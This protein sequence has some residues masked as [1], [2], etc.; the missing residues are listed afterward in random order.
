MAVT[1]Q[2]KAEMLVKKIVNIH[3][4]S[5]ISE[6]G[7]RGREATIE[8]NRELLEQKEDNNNL[9]NVTFVKA[10][11][12]CVLM[13]TK[14]TSPGKD[15][16][17]YTMRSHL[18]DSAKDILLELYIKV[19]EKGQLPQ[20][21]KDA[22]IVPVHKPGKDCTKPENYRPISLTSNICKIMK[23]MANERLIIWKTKVI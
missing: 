16:I 15:Q 22:V 17:C 23:R 2:E 18:S 1:D 21:W 11:L 10:E 9:L 8:E 14:M 5:N 20:L 19:L 7:Q 4:S 6:E 13:K 3:G 12:N